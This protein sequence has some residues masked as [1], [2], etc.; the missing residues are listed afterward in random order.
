MTHHTLKLKDRIFKEYKLTTLKRH[1]LKVMKG[2][3]KRQ[4][5]KLLMEDV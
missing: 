2:I 4:G 5:Y 3:K 1:Y